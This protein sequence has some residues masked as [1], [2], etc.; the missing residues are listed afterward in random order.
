VLNLL[1]DRNTL[2]SLIVVFGFTAVATLRFGQTWL[3]WSRDKY[4]AVFNAFSD[5]LLDRSLQGRLCQAVPVDVVITWVNGSDPV[6]ADSLKHA[7]ED[8]DREA[9]KRKSAASKQAQAGCP[10]DDCVASHM[11]VVESADGVR[12]F[13]LSDVVA[14][15]A[16]L[17]AAVEAATRPLQC[18]DHF[19]NK[20]VISFRSVEAAIK[21][22]NASSR[23]SL[24]SDNYEVKNEKSEP[25]LITSQLSNLNC[26]I[27]STFRLLGIL[28]FGFSIP[29][30]TRNFISVWI[31]GG[32]STLYEVKCPT[33]DSWRL[34]HCRFQ[35]ICSYALDVLWLGDRSTC[36]ELW[37][38]DCG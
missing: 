37:M 27:L 7:R 4:E 21:S 30:P 9:K 23:I 13:D 22:I 11:L 34:V 10:Y 6:F 24:S 1:L 31:D 18:E 14:R 20:S 25:H 2:I 16:H 26:L 29:Y 28:R 8:R 15:N 12:P 36:G 3:E 5:N 38:G 17:A 32:Q 19:Q 33:V 35:D